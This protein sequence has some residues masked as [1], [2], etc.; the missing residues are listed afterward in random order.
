MIHSTRFRLIVSF[1]AVSFIVGGVSLF[2]GGHLLYNA[3]LMEAD[4]QVRLALNAADDVYETHVKYV[5]VA[6]NITTLGSGFR[7][8]V[9]DRNR[10]DLVD[11]LGRMAQQADMDFAGIVTANGSTLCRIGPKAIPDEKS[12]LEN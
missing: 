2:I 7:A 1:L 8:S 12:Q 6:L 11:R 4:N 10:E 9:M 5:K 3:V